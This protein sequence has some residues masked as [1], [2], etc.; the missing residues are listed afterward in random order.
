[1]VKG[2]NQWLRGLYDR[3][4]GIRAERVMHADQAWRE[5]RFEHTE[6]IE[7]VAD[8]ALETNDLSP[9]AE[10]ERAAL[11]AQA[12]DAMRNEAFDAAEAAARAMLEIDDD[13]AAVRILAQ[14]HHARGDTASAASLFEQVI[15]RS[16]RDL[17]SANTLAQIRL[18]E[19]AVSEAKGLYGRVLETDGSNITACRGL[20]YI[21]LEQGNFTRAVRLFDT[22]IAVGRA[23]L[24][25]RLAFGGALLGVAQFAGARVAFYEAIAQNPDSALALAGL[26]EAAR[27]LGHLDDAVRY[28]RKASELDPDSGTLL[29]D[30]GITLLMQNEV[31]KAIEVLSFA[32]TV[33]PLSMMVRVPL[34]IALLAQ[35]NIVDA[36]DIAAET[37]EIM[38]PKRVPESLVSLG[39]AKM[40][41]GEVAEAEQ[42][43]CEAFELSPNVINASVGLLEARQLIG[44]MRR[45]ELREMFVSFAQH[46]LNGSEIPGH[47][48]EVG[49]PADKL[50]IA[51]LSANLTQ[52]RG[53]SRVAGLLQHHERNRFVVHCYSDTPNHDAVTDQCQQFAD[54][55]CESAHLS[56][57]DLAQR[58]AADQVDILIDLDGHRGHNR[59]KVLACKPARIQVAWMGHFSSVG[60]R[61]VEYV[62]SDVV[63]VPIAHEDEF[64]ES[65]L[66]IEGGGYCVPAPT[67]ACISAT[68]AFRIGGGDEES[69]SNVA[70]EAQQ[71]GFASFGAL[72]KFSGRALALWGEILSAVPSATLQLVS[73]PFVD[74]RVCEHWYQKL[75]NVGVA[76]ERVRLSTPQAI[77]AAPYAGVDVFL[78]ALPH[79]DLTQA[80][81]ALWHGVPAIT[82]MGETLSE[83]ASSGLLSAA[84]LTELVTLSD[85]KYVEMAIKLALEPT[86]RA[87]LGVRAKEGM[88]RTQSGDVR[89]FTAALEKSLLTI[90]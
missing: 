84:G 88:R 3:A 82:L 13:L 86:L 83:R 58:I 18:D 26:A 28:F 21:A 44:G 37:L 4:Q 75:A 14:V 40:R 49:P 8:A 53:G 71:V 42:Y 64:S 57:D 35:G 2:F 65:V 54:V 11:F 33:K 51:Y 67:T 19:D 62:L 60:I 6:V 66:R 10:R 79:T 5:A 68:D 23:D 9:E 15:A 90:A 69:T 32:L 43:L 31:G 1:L 46:Q 16:P 70:R 81:E 17:D 41:L 25:D 24:A 39:V 36:A 63:A 29:A 76:A 38:A 12:R 85:R 56:D 20:G 34:A 22:V 50:R 78:D 74:L 27:N 52:H 48:R 47:Q 55:W 77:A 30:L 89:L 61:A 45:A 87:D 7:E 80:G 72:P 59:V 73:V